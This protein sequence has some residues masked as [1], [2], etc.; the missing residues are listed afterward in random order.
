MLCLFFVR[1]PVLS[2]AIVV[3]SP[4]SSIDLNDLT[5]AFCFAICFMPST[6]MIVNATGKALGTAA[7]LSDNTNRNASSVGIPRNNDS[8]KTSTEAIAMLSL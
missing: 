1:V 7:T 4:T 8:A 2:V 6:V 3:M 5:S